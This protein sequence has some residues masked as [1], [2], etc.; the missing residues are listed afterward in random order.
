MMGKCSMPV[1]VV[2]VC[3][4]TWCVWM[5]HLCMVC[6]CMCVR[7]HD[8]YKCNI[9]AWYVCACVRVVCVCACV[10]VCVCVRVCA[11]VRVRAYVY[12]RT[13]ACAYITYR[14]FCIPLSDVLDALLSPLHNW[15]RWMGIETSRDVRMKV[16]TEACRNPVSHL[17][18]H[19]C[20]I[21]CA[22]F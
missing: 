21:M 10:C 20:V 15:G 5:Q 1:Q 12:T 14:H 18:I 9:Y 4:Y 13:R 16:L 6:V 11:C 2:C 19:I 17:L 8:V 22:L 7:T 3:A